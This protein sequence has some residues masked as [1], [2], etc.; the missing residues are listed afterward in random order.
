LISFHLKLDDMLR[1]GSMNRLR[2]GEGAS[3]FW[4]AFQAAIVA[5]PATFGALFVVY[6]Q[7]AD[8]INARLAGALELTNSRRDFAT[9][10]P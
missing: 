4:E 2:C 5:L 3:V 1:H 8:T 10:V 6:G 9:L 7:L